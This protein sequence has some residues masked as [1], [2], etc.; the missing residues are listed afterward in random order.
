MSQAKMISP[1]S[2]A[3]SCC[4]PAV[5]LL[6]GGGGEGGGGGV[7][8]QDVA[9][10]IQQA[11]AAYVPKSSVGNPDGV[12]GPLDSAGNLPATMIQL[13]GAA[14]Q[15]ASVVPDSSQ[16]ARASDTGKL[17]IGDGV[18]PFAMLPSLLSSAQLVDV[19]QFPTG[20]IP[21]S[22]TL[23]A[24]DTTIFALGNTMLPRPQYVGQ[25][26]RIHGGSSMPVDTAGAYM[27]R[28]PVYSWNGQASDPPLL[29]RIQGGMSTV[30]FV[31]I[32]AAKI[33]TYGYGPS[34]GLY[35]AC[36]YAA[37]AVTWGI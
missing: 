8:P 35:W 12:A 7:T 25:R 21:G 34:S 33:D 5:I 37:G 2:V 16:F 29:M 6:G 3:V 13:E 15:L 36:N 19:Q 1:P 32:D 9:V 18:T 31:G 26:V 30:E 17:V 24:L 20:A 4:V 23:T 22:V 27:F 11:L 28:I 14:S 10:M